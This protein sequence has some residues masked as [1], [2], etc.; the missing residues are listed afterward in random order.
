MHYIGF[1]F[2]GGT[3]FDRPQGPNH[4]RSFGGDKE[5]ASSW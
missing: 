3:T 4:G 5:H 2:I 1:S